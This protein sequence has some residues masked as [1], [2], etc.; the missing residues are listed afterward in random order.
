M[1]IQGKL[2][3]I[4][5]LFYIVN[6]L[7][8]HE[9]ASSKT[10]ADLCHASQRTIY[11]DIKKL[12]EVGFYFHVD[13]KYGYKLIHSPARIGN[14]LTLDE[15]MALTLF[16]VLS[17]GKLS[18]QH[19]LHLAYKKGLEKVSRFVRQADS[20]SID[21][22]LDDRIVFQNRSKSLQDNRILPIII[23]AMAANI[24]VEAEYYTI[25]RNDHN[26]RKLNPYVFVQREGHLYLVAY[27]HT[28]KEERVFRLDRFKVVRL[29]E[30]SF[31]IPEEFTIDRFLSERWSI[32]DEGNRTTFVVYFDSDV[33]R[34]VLEQSFNVDPE[35]ERHK[36]GSVTL[37]VTVK[38][39]EEFL[40]W[41]RSF[42]LHATVLSPAQVREKLRHEYK[43][44]VKR[45]E[46]T[47]NNRS[48]EGWK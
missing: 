4:E 9:Y 35:I 47:I 10:L 16:P 25:S 15:F 36:D 2:N 46:K 31:V 38:S 19:P 29:T 5:R 39:T 20:S 40:R 27:C 32:M 13:P 18:E 11:R 45:Y 37:K 21:V 8:N 26:T 44:L 28:R 43:E 22:I 14:H 1:A 24:V 17:T 42:G 41:V 23:N 12:E 33:S 30:E 6:Y 48:L 7:T 34:Y 3:H